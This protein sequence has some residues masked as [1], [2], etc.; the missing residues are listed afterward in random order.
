MSYVYDEHNRVTY[1]NWSWNG[2]PEGS[3][4][5][6]YDSSTHSYGKGRLTDT[7]GPAGLA[8]YYYDPLGNLVQYYWES[9]ATGQGYNMYYDYNDASSLE[10]V[11]YPDGYEV[12]YQFNPDGTSESLD[13]DLD[14]WIS[15]VYDADRNIVRL[16]SGANGPSTTNMRYYNSYDD[17]GRLEQL[18]DIKVSSPFN[19]LLLQRDLQY[20]SDDKISHIDDYQNGEGTDSFILG[21]D[22]YG[23]L[24]S[25]GGSLFIDYDY[26][27]A[28]R[29]TEVVVGSDTTSYSYNHS[30]PWAPTNLDTNG[31]SVTYTYDDDGFTS[32]WQDA[33]HSDYHDA[34]GLLKSQTTG[35]FPVAIWAY[36]HFD[37]RVFHF[38]GYLFGPTTDFVEKYY[39]R[40]VNLSQNRKYI[41]FGGTRIAMLDEEG[42]VSYFHQNELG[43]NRMI[44]NDG[45]TL[46]A[47]NKYYPF[48]G[49]YD[50]TGSHSSN[51][52]FNDR[53][54]EGYN[55]YLYFPARMYDPS[56]RT[57]ASIDPAVL[58]N[59]S[60]LM[61]DG[62]NPY[63]YCGND[64]VNQMDPMGLETDE[65]NQDRVLQDFV[66]NAV[67]G[68]FDGF[69]FAL[70]G[71][72]F[73]YSDAIGYRPITW[74]ER[75]PSCG[76][77]WI[78][79]AGFAGGMVL[80]V[81]GA[82]SAGVAIAEKYSNDSN[83]KER[84]ENISEGNSGS[85]TENSGDATSGESRFIVQP[86]GTVV[87]TE[88]T[89][90]R[91][92]DQPDGGRTDI[93]QKKD[94]GAG[95][96]HTHD[97]I[98]NTNPA[99][100]E[101]FQNGVKKPGRPVSQNDVKNIKEGTAPRSE[102]KGR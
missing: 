5:L 76:G 25:M 65:E 50:A 33:S 97:P 61:K 98:L 42:A 16:D 23:R 47:S 45:G 59:P 21:Y 43:S 60:I 62:T 71:G 82:V 96:S 27:R 30:L 12:T 84:S 101:T 54:E 46:L 92:Y 48:G 37:R 66:A 35:L 52:K 75:C 56:R 13:D 80:G 6:S 89:P 38:P 88:A 11:T 57:W 72:T 20:Y 31:N 73:V 63:A 36:D 9:D 7:D 91:S 94:H 102:P 3:Y 14:F 58:L 8:A 17:C 81:G 90:Q 77:Q 22:N 40:D 55:D 87:D 95:Q 83:G 68:L 53:R 79:P 78:Y 41:Y 10:S 34:R 51:R 44:T 49:T 67:V 85:A 69:F 70:S 2:T 19:I 4:E 28:D 39:E 64:P 24:A 74:T 1:K 100:G 26:D 29:I 15:A 32:T 86:D 18:S 93:L 99:T